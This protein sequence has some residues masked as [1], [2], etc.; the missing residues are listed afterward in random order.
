M[1]EE[2]RGGARRRV[3]G[4][5]AVGVYSSARVNRQLPSSCVGVSLYWKHTQSAL[6]QWLSHSSRERLLKR[7]MLEPRHH[8][9]WRKVKSAV[10]VGILR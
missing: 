10:E 6:R 8:W 9:P 1:E 4:R 2:L 3:V 5:A 7:R